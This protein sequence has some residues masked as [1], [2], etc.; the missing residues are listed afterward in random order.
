[1]TEH[2]VYVYGVAAAADAASL[3][4]GAGAID[5]RFPLEPLGDGE[6]VA[7]VSDVEPEVLRRGVDGLGDGDLSQLESLVRAHEQVLSRALAADAL[8]PFRFGTVVESRDDVVRLLR[9]RGEQL[10]ARLAALRGACEWGV[11]A[12]VDADRFDATL[13]ADEPVLAELESAAASG[14]GSAFFARKRLERDLDERRWQAAGEVAVGI[15]R[16]IASCAREATVTA[17]QPREISG[18]ADE[19]ILNGAYLVARDREDALRTLVADLAAEL[20]DRGVHL[21]LTGPWPAFS[22]VGGEREP[23]A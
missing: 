15:H 18:Y 23:S 19:M 20:D 3:P 1:V 8:V 9:E 5:P 22:F 17:P 4:Q 12:L 10:V 7:L 2:G 11:K 6:L 16:R 21:E 14:G 13:A